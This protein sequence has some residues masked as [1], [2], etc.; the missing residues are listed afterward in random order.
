M[1][2]SDSL[3]L[4]TAHSFLLSNRIN[5][6]LNFASVLDDSLSDSKCVGPHR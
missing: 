4:F 2:S 3:D 5:L 1:T 6:P